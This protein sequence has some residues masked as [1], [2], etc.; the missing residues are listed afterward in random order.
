MSLASLL[1]LLPI[2]SCSLPEKRKVGPAG[3]GGAG[4]PRARPKIFEFFFVKFSD[5]KLSN[6]KHGFVEIQNMIMRVQK[7]FM[8]GK[9]YTILYAMQMMD[10]CH[11]PHGE[12][13]CFESGAGLS[14]PSVRCHRRMESWAMTLS[15]ATLSWVWVVLRPSLPVIPKISYARFD[16]WHSSDC[17]A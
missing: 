13:S 3:L 6:F 10:M 8:Q 14:I 7:K 9:I 12:G 2:P 4:R 17:G 16:V 5:A 1:L 11:V 15:S